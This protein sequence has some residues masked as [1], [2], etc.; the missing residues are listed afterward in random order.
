MIWRV[1][2]FFM[3]FLALCDQPA[4]DTSYPSYKASEPLYQGHRFWRTR[5]CVPPAKTEEEIKAEA[6][7]EYIEQQMEDGRKRTNIGLMLLLGGA[8]LSIA[9]RSQLGQFPGNLAFAAG[10]TTY[11]HGKL[12]LADAAYDRMITIGVAIAAIAFVLFKATNFSAF[13]ALRNF[14]PKKPS[15]LE[16]IEKKDAP[17]VVDE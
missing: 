6:R 15:Q 12:I 17:D 13:E 11:V 9:F 5:V 14:L 16:L 7:R 2:L 4:H 1:V 10:A 8:V 3:A